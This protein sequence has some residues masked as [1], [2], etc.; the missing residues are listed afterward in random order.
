MDDPLEIKH[1]LDGAEE[2]ERHYEAKSVNDHVIILVDARRNMFE[3]MDDHGQ[4]SALPCLAASQQGRAGGPCREVSHS[5]H[6]KSVHQERFLR[7]PV[8]FWCH[9]ENP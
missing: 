8:H 2:D 9:F 1:E 6:L 5:K 3:S 7:K 4:V